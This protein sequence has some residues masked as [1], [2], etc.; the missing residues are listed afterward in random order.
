MLP[1]FVPTTCDR[2]GKPSP[3]HFCSAI[4]PVNVPLE[5]LVLVRTREQLA[6]SP[7]GTVEEKNARE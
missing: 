2:R 4:D 7:L 1:N 6:V 3:K 5:S